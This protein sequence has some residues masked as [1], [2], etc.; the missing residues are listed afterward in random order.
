MCTHHVLMLY[1]PSV[2]NCVG[3]TLIW[4]ERP[5]ENLDVLPLLCAPPSSLSCKPCHQ[6]PHHTRTY[7]HAL[8]HTHA[9][10]LTHACAD[11]CTRACRHAHTYTCTHTRVHRRA[12]THGRVCT[13][14]CTRAHTDACTRPH[15]HTHIQAR[16]HA[17]PHTH[18]PCQPSFSE[19][20]Q[21]CVP[22][23]TWYFHII[24]VL[25]V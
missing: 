24:S 1:L 12:R 3:G 20:F 6:Q 22:F 23:C 13:P 9:H 25:W 17:C 21:T 14:T 8:A 16:T 19:M 5:K 2:G 15:A 10:A 18:R 7:T 4:G 11:A